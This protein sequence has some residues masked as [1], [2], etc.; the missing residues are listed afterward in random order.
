MKEKLAEISAK[1]ASF[2]EEYADKHKLIS[3]AV[4]ELL[5]DVPLSDYFD[6]KNGLVTSKQLITYLMCDQ[7]TWKRS[8]GSNLARYSL[9]DTCENIYKIRAI[10]KANGFCFT[11]F[12]DAALEALQKTMIGS[13]VGRD[14]ILT[15]DPEALG[16]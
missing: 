10:D 4:T 9:N 15:G 11:L 13:K 5:K 7:Q 8:D 1:N 3:S 2:E 6:P 16:A 12:H 14:E